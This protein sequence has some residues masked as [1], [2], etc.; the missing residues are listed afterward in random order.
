M[1]NNKERQD[2]LAEL[3]QLRQRTAELESLLGEEGLSRLPSKHADENRIDLSS[4][5]FAQL[6][7]QIPGYAYYKDFHGAY[8]MANQTFANVLGVEPEQIVGKTD[9]DLVPHEIAQKYWDE[10]LRILSGQDPILVVEEDETYKGNTSFVT[11]RKAPIRDENGQIIGLIGV[12]FDISEHR[13]I[14]EELEKERL[15]IRTVIDNI[16]DQ[17]FVRDRNCRFLLNNLSDARVM[18]VQDPETLVGKGDEDFYPPDL[19]A[20]YQADDRQVMDSGQALINR[21]EPSITADGKQH[22]VLTTKAPLRDGQGEVIGLVGIARDITERKLAERSLLEA[23]QRL[24]D[25][26]AHANAM[27]IEANNANKA[28]SEFLANMSHEIRTPMNGVIGM[29]GLLLDTDLSQ[30]QRRLAEIVRSSGESLLGLINDILDFSKIE[31]RK[32]DLELLDFDLRAALEDTTEILASRAVEKG[33]ELVCMVDPE[34]P[35]FLRGD[36]GRLRQVIL[37]LAG[38]A[39]KFTSQ[40]EVAIRVSLEK[41]NSNTAILKFAIKDTGIGIP[42]DRLV[43]LFQPFSQVDGSTTRKYG[44]TGLG[45]AISKQLAEMMGGQIGVESVANQG[46]T[47][48]FT[49]VFTRQPEGKEHEAEK[50]ADM[51]GVRVLVVDDNANNLMLVQSL[52]HTWKCQTVEAKNGEDAFKMLLEAHELGRPFEAAIIDRMMAGMDGIELGRRIKA[53]EAVM[54]THLILMT[55]MGQ[56]GDVAVLEEIG[57]SGYLNKPFRQSHLHDSL[58]M[59]LGRQH[60]PAEKQPAKKLITQYS[61]SEAARQRVRLLLAEDNPVNQMVVVTLLKK[62][63]YRV[64]VVANGREAVHALQRIPY[65]LVFMD[66]QMP[67]MDGFEATKAIRLPESKVLNSHIPVIAL[68]AYAMQGDRERCEQAGMDDYLAKPIRPAELSTVLERWLAHS[69][70]RRNQKGKATG[71]ELERPGESND[72]GP[73]GVEMDEAVAAEL[74]IFN[75]DQ[76][77]KRLMNDVELENIIVAAFL[78]EMPKQIT[79]MKQ[80]LENQDIKNIYRLAHTI[81]GGASYLSANR[82]SQ[83]AFQAEKMAE[84]DNV[85]GVSALLPRIEI[86]FSRFQEVISKKKTT[87]KK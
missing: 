48:W 46:S 30:E 75:E 27:T 56:R 67:E 55:S 72:S 24:E 33:L 85:D 40:G 82:L 47:F 51:E 42:T 17:I 3:A 79:E 45:L 32:L 21:E 34:V 60:T 11:Y 53:N 76:L 25:A 58:S 18:G 4:A 65:D 81:K 5:L 37:N 9:F 63:G 77:L 8:V 84:N 52:L 12:G 44:G 68:T 61:M 71:I 10:D 73:A 38:N 7:K 70:Q 2:L 35:S 59:V 23:N 29:T 28:K 66:C 15:L 14:E 43:V 16:P 87:I 86:E 13:H 78:D 22:W 62:Q 1:I 54:D 19:S 6:M 83:E 39:I 57:F 49:A 31:A 36:P 41:E 26:I 74:E 20:I 64:D 80:Y 50:L 69:K